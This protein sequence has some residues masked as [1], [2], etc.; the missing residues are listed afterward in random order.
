MTLE[1]RKQKIETYRTGYQQLVAAVANFPQAMWQYR[2]APDRWTIHEIIV[3]I[4]DSEAN[5]YIRCRRFLAEPGSAVLGYD[6]MKWAQALNY[7]DQSP[8]AALE[9]FRWLRQQSYELIRDLPAETWLNTVNHSENGL[10]TLETWLDTYA[11]H[12]PDHIQQMRQVY[13]DWVRTNSSKTKLIQ[14]IDSAWTELQTFLA[15]LSESQMTDL[16]DEQGWNVRDH[17]TH[18]AVW[19]QSILFLFQGKPRHLALGIPLERLSHQY[20]DEIN[21][22]IRERRQSYSIG[23]A[24]QEFSEIHSGLLEQVRLLSD[25]ELGLLVVQFFSYPQA[26]DERRVF[27]IVRQNTADHFLEHLGWIKTLV[28]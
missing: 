9:L 3:H 7:H 16:Q 25:A 13:V 6:E 12:I 1:D 5:S 8:Q 23:A 21:A 14:E 22:A 4:T 2:P 11:R 20:F 10:M 28:S 19:E 27:E 24:L 26:G 15:G 17:I 18:L